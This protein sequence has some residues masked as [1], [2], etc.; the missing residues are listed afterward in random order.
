MQIHIME[1]LSLQATDKTEIGTTGLHVTRL[2][3]GGVALSGAPPATDPNQTTSEDEATQLIRRSLELGLNGSD[4]NTE[5][6]NIVTGFDVS[7][8][9]PGSKLEMYF[10]YDRQTVDQVNTENRLY[11]D[12]RQEW[13]FGKS[14]WG[15]FLHASVE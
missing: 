5:T 1:G 7:R 2:G 3:L 14:P 6:F 12:I 9:L 8:T 10:D 15:A 11:Y 4:G 13:F